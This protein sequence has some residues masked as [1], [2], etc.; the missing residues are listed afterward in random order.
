MIKLLP[1]RPPILLQATLS[2]MTN[3]SAPSS[4]L[5]FLHHSLARSLAQSL[6]E[7]RVVLAERLLVRHPVNSSAALHRFP[8]LNQGHTDG[9]LCQAFKLVSRRSEGQRSTDVLPRR[10]LFS[11]LAEVELDFPFMIRGLPST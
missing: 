10:L 2:V 5:P 6:P 4:S 3:T 9:F 1:P 8:P 7:L 11:A